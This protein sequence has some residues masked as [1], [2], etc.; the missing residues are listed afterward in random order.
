MLTVNGEVRGTGAAGKVEQAKREASREAFVNMGWVDP[1]ADI[2]D[3][4]YDG[5]VE[6]DDGSETIMT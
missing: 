6:S 5:V 4:N 1:T 3:N 2:G